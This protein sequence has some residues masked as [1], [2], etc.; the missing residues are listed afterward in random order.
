[1]KFGRPKGVPGVCDISTEDMQ[2]DIWGRQES[3][4]DL[5]NDFIG[6]PCVVSQTG[7]AITNVEVSMNGRDIIA[8]VRISLK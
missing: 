5:T 2:E 3:C 8:S 6:P 7:N 1:M 4:A